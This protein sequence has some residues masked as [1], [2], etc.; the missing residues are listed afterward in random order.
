M[1]RSRGGLTTKVHLATDGAGRGLAV[2]LTP[3]QTNDLPLLPTVLDA[4]VVPRLEGEPPRRNPDVAIADPTARYRTEPFCGA[5]ASTSSFQNAAIRS[6]TK[7]KGRHGGRA[8]LFDAELY[9]RRYVIERVLRKAKHRRA[10]ASR[11][12]SSRPP[13]MPDSFWP[14]SSNGSNHRE[15]RPGRFETSAISGGSSCRGHHKCP[16]TGHPSQ[17]SAAAMSLSL[18]R[19]RFVH[20]RKEIMIKSSSAAA[21]AIAVGALIALPATPAHAQSP[22]CAKAI[23]LI[24][25]AIDTTGGTMDEA[26]ATALSGRLSGLAETTQGAERDAIA[27][28]ANAL[29]DAGVADLTPFTDEL[30]RACA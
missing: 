27:A 29:I 22:S 23:E 2:L 25:I 24:N 5:K 18:L 15:T 1:G 14:S 4:L 3:G 10:V 30:N 13:S 17:Y 20:L 12:D 6:P 9:K 28:Y 16:A 11:Y 7:R 26:T 21:L 8:P 19:S